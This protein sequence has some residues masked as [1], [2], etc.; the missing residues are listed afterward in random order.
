[1]IGIDLHDAEV[2]ADLA[3]EAGRAH[4]IGEV[5]RLTSGELD[6]LVLCAGVAA[7][8]PDEHVVSVNYFGA[9][10]LL[11]GLR[12]ELESGR[13]PAAV[14]VASSAIV[15]G[16]A[17]AVTVDRC[18]AEDEAGARAAAAIAPQAGYASAK[19]ALALDVR[20]LAAA[21]EWLGRGITVNAVAPGVVRTP[22][23]APLIADPGWV[24]TVPTTMGRYADA[25]EV[26]GV[27]AFFIGPFARFVTGQV[28]FADGGAEVSRHAGRVAAR[29]ALES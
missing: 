13:Q 4:A 25:F 26:A 23:T 10:S 22:M 2:V 24:P 3:T 12:P 8:Q 29:S 20:R 21:P 18:L 11:K 7:A 16:R 6:A 14:V 19:L 27:L 15:F 17:D 1:V 5:R 9:H 28:L